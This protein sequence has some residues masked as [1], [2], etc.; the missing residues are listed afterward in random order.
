M[1]KGYTYIL[2]SKE[3][4]TIYT[5]VTS[6]LMKRLW[7]HK[8]NIVQGFTSRYNV[9]N[10]VYYEEYGDIYDAIVREKQIK[11]WSRKKKLNLINRNNPK[12]L[13]LSKDWFMDSSEA[14]E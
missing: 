2:A 13:D 9:H 8:N 5:G 6:D 11:G 12:W 1:K 3:N 14:S 7:Q 4:G 10:L